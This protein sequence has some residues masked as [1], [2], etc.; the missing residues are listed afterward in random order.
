MD[1]KVD[2]EISAVTVYLDRA[3][4]TCK[5]NVQVEAGAQTLIFD[6][7]PL[8]IELDSVRVGGR[9]TGEIQI[10]GVDVVRQ[11][12]KQ[13]PS[14][15]V[16]ELEEQIELLLNEM[17]VL[18]DRNAGFEAQAEH[19]HGMR[20]ETR[21][22]AKGL[23]RGRTTVDDQAKLIQF[24][25]K[26]DEEIRG[27]QREIEIKRRG[28]ERQ[29][30]KLQNEL[31][32]L[33]NLR[34]RQRFQARVDIY[35]PVAAEFQPELAF[36]LRSAGWQPLYDIRLSKGEGRQLLEVSTIAQVT[37]RTGQDW[38]GVQLSVSTARPALNQ[39]LPEIKPW[40]VDEYQPPQPRQLKTRSTASE[41]SMAVMAAPQADFMKADMLLEDFQEAGVTH[42]EV[43]DSGA[44]VT[45]VVSGRWDIPSD[46][47]PHKM[48]L[49]SFKLDPNIDFI[50][51]PRHTDVVY[52]RANMS[53]TGESPMLAGMATLFVGDEFIGKT[54]IGYTP[55][56]GELEL[57]LGVEERIKIERE[58]AKRDVDKR[59]LRENRLVRY[60][61][62]IKLE[63][64]MKAPVNI[65]VQDQIPVSRHEQIKIK[66]DRARPELDD[67]TDLNIL[68]WQLVLEPGEKSTI[69]Y[70][71]VIEH[72]RS[73]R[74]S[75]LA[76]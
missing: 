21:E 35:V 46:G 65:E 13:S 27:A 24:L 7:M 10:L 18:D 17:R 69:S 72:P 26:Q 32:D 71:Y 14:P 36:I 73:M 5:G 67:R 68:E 4:L 76:E 48:V 66:L 60:A 54:R 64:L 1:R 31:E 45:Y 57:L 44:V 15:Q 42:A 52:R 34:P 20:L 25:E 51:I 38:T 62:D 59:L 40:F 41:P 74:I 33:H 28:L 39:R 29:L 11:H 22:Y 16:I 9:G 2:Y 37:Q 23:S 43:K 53:N 63:N 50:T 30:E 47:S 58:L 12:Y 61:Y 49:D 3:R 75:G 70:E 6:E 55:L 8:T 56:G 19:L